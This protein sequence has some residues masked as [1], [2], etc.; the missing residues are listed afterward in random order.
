MLM[1]LVVRL[2]CAQNLVFVFFHRMRVSVRVC[3][4]VCAKTDKVSDDEWIDVDL[5]IGGCLFSAYEMVFTN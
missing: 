3:A 5:R 1:V 4:C 2:M